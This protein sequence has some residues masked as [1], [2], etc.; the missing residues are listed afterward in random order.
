MEY[1]QN[2]TANNLKIVY[3]YYKEKFDSKKHSP[4]LSEREFYHYIR[5]IPDLD[6]LYIKICNY[7]DGI[8]NVITILD[9]NGNIITFK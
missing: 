6:T 2:R 9:P 1:I 7:Y 3:E 8:Y 5:M 4:F